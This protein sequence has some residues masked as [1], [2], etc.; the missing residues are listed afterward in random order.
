MLL[1]TEFHVVCSFLAVNI[2]FLLYASVF[3]LV[4]KM[5]DS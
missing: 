5:F 1:E 2:Q 3:I 4:E